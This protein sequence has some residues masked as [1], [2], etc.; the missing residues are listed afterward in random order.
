MAC[1]SVSAPP[2]SLVLVG[3][4]A[5]G[6]VCG[7]DVA[8]GVTLLL[9]FDGSTVLCKGEREGWLRV[10]ILGA[11]RKGKW[12]GGKVWAQVKGGGDEGVC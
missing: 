9:C 1:R 3:D 7:V 6:F 8:F 5:E 4:F 11:V 12:C 10:S 2:F